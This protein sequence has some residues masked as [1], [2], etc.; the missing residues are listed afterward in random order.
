MR[1]VQ[2]NVGCVG[3]ESELAELAEM[4]RK[5]KDERS[6]RL[7]LLV[8]PAGIGKSRLLS[9]LR[10]KVRLSGGVV[11]EGRCD[12]GV[13]FAP[14]AAIVTQALRFLEEIGQPLP[15]D[16]AAL[17][18]ASGCHALWYQHKGASEAPE[19]PDFAR[20]RDRFFDA[21]A[22]LL[23]HVAAVRTPVVML[24]DL[25][26][27]DHGTLDLLHALLDAGTPFAAS[28]GKPL[29]ALLTA[30]VRSDDQ[31]RIPARVS[32]LLEHDTAQ[33]LTLGALNE[34]GVRALL[35]SPEAVAQIL[36]RTG[37]S[38]DAI[39]RLLDVT[40]PSHAEHVRNVLLALPTATRSAVTALAL[41]GRP[42]RYAD[43]EQAI[44]AKLDG[45]M[46]RSLESLSWLEGQISD[47]ELM[48]AFTREAEKL[49]LIEALS[50]S[51]RQA[52]HAG[53]LRVLEARGAE[54]E[55]RARHALLSGDHARACA[56]VLEAARSL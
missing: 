44:D 29:S 6:A 38:P 43:L 16:F 18:C 1:E 54:A 13:A 50:A 30:C 24:H 39:R 15:S 11:L 27:A 32:A 22:N 14:F 4:H 49:A 34:A 48:I 23:A 45:A 56:L 3:R 17:A 36:A 5:A 55:D 35:T 10:T 40:P 26:H 21:V 46:R 37:G 20:S 53:W 47:G 51:E 41:A 25:D 42:A 31:Q 52:I 33:R 9:A 19:S 7:A 12:A 2:G 8:G 28:L